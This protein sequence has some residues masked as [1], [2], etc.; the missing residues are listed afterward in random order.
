MIDKG[1]YERVAREAFLFS[2][3]RT[4]ILELKALT[5]VYEVDQ[6]L[7]RIWKDMIDLQYMREG[8]KK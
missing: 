7:D 3:I 4:D 2:R 6:S 8:D 1:D 5:P